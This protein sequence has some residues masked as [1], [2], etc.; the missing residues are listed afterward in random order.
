MRGSVIIALIFAIC[1]L[2]CN[3]S[4]PNKSTNVPEE[5]MQNMIDTHMSET[6][7][8]LATTHQFDNREY[9]L[10]FGRG[11][12]WNGTAGYLDSS[13]TIPLNSDHK[14]AIGSITKMFTATVVLQL[15][16]TGQIDLDNNIIT[17]L[18]T[19]MAQVLDSIQ[20]GSQ[21]TVR[22]ALS[23]RSGLFDYIFCEGF[24]DD[25]YSN[26]SEYYE[27]VDILRMVR[28]KGQPLFEPGT[29]YTYSSTNY[30]LLGTLIENVT[31]KTFA[32]VIKENICDRIRLHDTYLAEG[33]YGNGGDDIANGY[34]DEYGM[35]YNILDFNT[36]TAWAAGGMISTVGDL[37][38]FIKSLTKG[39]L[40][41][42][43]STYDLM[44][45]TGANET[46]ALGISIL[47][48]E[49]Y[50][51]FIGHGGA[52]IGQDSYCFFIPNYN[53]A[54]SGCSMSNGRAER[55]SNFAIAL[56]L[57]DELLQQERS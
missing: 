33:L 7:G 26:P 18:P 52:T 55:L 40:F 30:Y 6:Y 41:A 39:L 38:K 12:L 2:N 47:S 17:Y 16:E 32:N 51:P 9:P 27:P 23:M 45:N 8:I 28:D 50:G 14:F 31:G 54:I 13:M 48:H 53:I 19:E 56:P 20:Y 34:D 4:S 1:Y 3:K 22:Q 42:N 35:T 44:I 43:E 24:Y 46:Y 11:V 21:I 25:L 49:L 10:S 29:S 36:S 5:I 15:M 37:N 57:L